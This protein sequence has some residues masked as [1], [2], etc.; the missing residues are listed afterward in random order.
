MSGGAHRNHTL[1][2]METTRAYASFV[3]VWPPQ[4]NG[5]TQNTRNVADERRR[6]HIPGRRMVH[7]KGRICSTRTESSKVRIWNAITLCSVRAHWILHR[8]ENPRYYGIQVKYRDSWVARIQIKILYKG[9]CLNAQT[10][11]IKAEK[12]YYFHH[13]RTTHR[14]AAVI[15]QVRKGAPDV[16]LS[17]LRDR[18]QHAWRKRVY[19]FS[20][21]HTKH[22]KTRNA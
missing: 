2:T 17:R 16:E 6:S 18:F 13:D 21:Q 14:C 5:L 20:T 19:V 4:P 15:V 7:V 10:E 3:T 9:C 11:W 8:A 12:L 1:C 22:N